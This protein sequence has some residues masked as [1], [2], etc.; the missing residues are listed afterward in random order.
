MFPTDQTKTQ[1]ISS[2]EL[3]SGIGI[4]D[5]ICET[6]LCQTEFPL[7]LSIYLKIEPERNTEELIGELC[8]YLNCNTLISD[9]GPNPFAMKLIQNTK[10]CKQIFYDIS[11]FDDNDSFEL[12]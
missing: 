7:I 5:I 11:R 6:R 12:L 8:S 1:I 10:E 3:S 4:M 2:I 9:K